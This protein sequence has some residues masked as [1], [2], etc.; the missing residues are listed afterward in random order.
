[1]Q[2]RRSLSLFVVGLIVIASASDRAPKRVPLV[3][4]AEIEAVKAR[5]A[6]ALHS[7]QLDELSLLYAPDG[8]FLTRTT[9]RVTGRPAIRE[10]FEKVLSSYSSNIT[11][12]SFRIERS[13]DLAYD[14]GDF[15]ETVTS[16]TNGK[17]YQVKGNYLMIFK[18]TPGGQWLIVEQV[19]TDREQVAR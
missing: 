8:S 7:K 10:L 17:Q 18:R 3:S 5:L 12:K 16:V 6:D 2:Y 9:G 14:S 13:N 1:M 19:M 15:E 4:V 11:L